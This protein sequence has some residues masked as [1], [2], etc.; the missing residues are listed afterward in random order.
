[1]VTVACGIDLMMQG[2]NESSVAAAAAQY[3][4]HK[5]G[6]ALLIIGFVVQC[7]RLAC[8]LLNS[9][10]NSSNIPGVAKTH[11][12]FWRKASQLMKR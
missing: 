10:W 6:Y 1:M 2:V 12:R 11:F 7:L 4:Q 3:I 8:S 9:L 5:S